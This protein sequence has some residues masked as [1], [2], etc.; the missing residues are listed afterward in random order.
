MQSSYSEQGLSQ[1]WLSSKIADFN[2]AV[3]DEHAMDDFDIS[4]LKNSSQMDQRAPPMNAFKFGNQNGSQSYQSSA[5]VVSIFFFKFNP[6]L[7]F[8]SETAVRSSEQPAFSPEFRRREISDDDES[9]A[10]ATAKYSAAEGV[11]V[12]TRD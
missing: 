3:D 9:V 4:T 1:S 2:D 6:H 7:V 11:G 12:E 5:P 10:A 8:N